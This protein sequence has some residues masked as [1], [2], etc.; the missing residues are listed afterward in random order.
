[1]KKPTAPQALLILAAFLAPVFGGYV[2]SDQTVVDPSNLLGSMGEG[3]APILQHALIALPVFVALILLLVARRVQQIPHPYV[4]ASLMLLV[5]G[6]GPAV[7]V[8]QYRAVSVNVWVEWAAYAVAFLAAVSGLGRRLGPK[9][10]LGAVF[11]GSVWVALRGIREYGDMRSIDP[12]WRVFAGWS[13]PNA[14]A[15]MLTLG[16]FCGLALL[17]TKERLAALGAVLGGGVILFAIFLTGSKGATLFALPL[18][19]V[20]YALVRRPKSVALWL[21]GGLAIVVLPIAFL[22]SFALASVAVELLALMALIWQGRAEA[23]RSSLRALGV[24]GVGAAFVLL[25]LLTAAKPSASS[26]LAG[27]TPGSRI[28]ASAKTQ[29][30]SATFRLNLWKSAWRLFQERPITGWGLGSYR[31]ESARPGLATSTVFAHNS[32]LQLLAEAGIGSLGLFLVFLGLWGWRSFRGAARLPDEGRLP[33][34]AAVGGAVA[35]LAHCVVD[36]DLSYFGLG[37]AFF[38]VLGA[39]TL[40]AADAV[41]PEFIP[42]PS[43]LV[44]AGCM[45]GLWLMFAYLAWGDLAKSEVRF[46]Q[47]QTQGDVASIEGLAGWDGDAAYLWA[48]AQGPGAEAGLKRAFE[49]QPTPK[50]ARSLARV[51]EARGAF[52]EAEG[53]LFPALAHDPNNLKVLA[54]LMQIRQESGDAAGAEETARRLVA[55]ESSPYFR[56]RSLDELVPTETYLARVQVLAPAEKDARRKA[57]LLAEATR[58][59]RRYADIT[60]PTVVRMTKDDPRGNYGGET[61]ATARDKLTTGATAAR[62]AAS[63]Y[64]SLDDAKSADDMAAQASALEKAV[65]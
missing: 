15:A 61:L 4:A 2:A 3:Y 22:K 35:M 63:L 8:S 17:G 41:A 14:T 25:L 56:I 16:F 48:V 44:A 47:A 32:Y 24:Y 53:A 57:D 59:L 23:S 42:R 26:S 21:V 6:L 20:V 64:K 11:V 34:A 51:Q 33:F 7:A 9:A 39:A 49:M 65:P 40:L 37:L 58:G 19:T 46:A 38:L 50:I 60:V 31:Y 52:A 5:A 36:S 62:A 12:T 28:A 29:D 54:L 43:R 10:L 30:Q 27:V 45:A 55:V 13:N 18:G 1:M